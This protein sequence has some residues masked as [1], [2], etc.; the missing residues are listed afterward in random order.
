MTLSWTGRG[1]VSRAEGCLA[2][3][4]QQRR[5]S[6]EAASEGGAEGKQKKVDDE[7]AMLMSATGIAAQEEGKG[8]AVKRTERT[9][10][11]REKG[12]GELIVFLSQS[13]SWEQPL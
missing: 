8:E 5:E 1:G 9:E 2:G 11:E 4:R 3:Q 7:S 13:D 10:W 6:L 12:K